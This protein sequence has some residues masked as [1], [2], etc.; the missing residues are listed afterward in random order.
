MTTIVHRIALGNRNGEIRRSEFN[1]INEIVNRAAAT[2]EGA[3][4]KRRHFGDTLKAYTVACVTS[5]NIDY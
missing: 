3:H 2:K 4:S 1:I 5:R